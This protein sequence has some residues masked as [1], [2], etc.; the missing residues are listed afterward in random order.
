MIKFHG[1]GLSCDHCDRK[2]DTKKAYDK[3]MSRVKATQEKRD[4]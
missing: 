3:H 1:E 2:F 4:R